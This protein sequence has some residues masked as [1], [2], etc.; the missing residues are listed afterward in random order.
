MI[1]A[2]QRY[3]CV[4]YGLTATK[5]VV[6][7][8][9]GGELAS[10]LG[11]T[12][13][14][15]EGDASTV[16]MEAAWALTARLVREA[17]ARAGSGGAALAGVGV[18]G[19]GGGVYPVDGE[20]Q[21]VSRALTSMDGRARG[22]VEQWAAEGRSV[23]ALTRHHPWAGQLLPQVRFLR[24]AAHADYERTRW[25]LGAKDWLVFRLTGG[26][27]ADR[28]DASNDGLLDLATGHY[29]PAIFEVMGLPDLPGKLAPVSE[30]SAVV[31]TVS[32]RAAAE[33]G[34]PPG[35][36][37]VAG[38]CD[39]VACAVGSGAL[40]ERSASLIAG[41]WNINSV[42][43][44]RL[45]EVPPS[46]KTSL[47][48]DAGRFAYVESSATS[49]G[50]LAW[51]LA[52]AEELTGPTPGGHA[53]LYARMNAGVARVP[54]GAGGVTYLPFIHRAHL[55][56]GVDA[57]FTGMRADHGVFHL[58]RALYEGVAFAHRAHL[59]VLE[60]GGLRRERAVLSGGAATSPVW[61]DIFAN[62]LGRP[63]E[64]SDAAQAGARGIAMAIA[65][66][67]GAQRSYEEAARVMV[68]PGRRHVPDPRLAQVYEEGYSR[69]REAARRLG[70]EPREAGV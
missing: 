5:A 42:F 40:D 57:A 62:V 21:P 9:T 48:P 55:A 2:G 16:D 3:L 32:A 33:T 68:R 20:G 63:I 18:S 53:A 29:G 37:V 4:D 26:A 41:T 46:V 15:A 60:S 17:L 67:T 7:D 12:P 8:E 22:L 10:A 38:M 45:L 24:E 30:S 52:R 49:A 47:G 70:A 54:A 50:N 23:H 56:P 19:H 36:P 13:V 28:T 11:D 27:S 35:L 65:I 51:F 14:L 66:G 43:D 1:V 6:F 69:F 25:A 31:G 64:T 59:E 61:C 34:L 58:L 44:H 39:V